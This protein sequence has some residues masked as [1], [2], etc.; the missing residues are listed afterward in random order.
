MGWGS[1]ADIFVDQE[2]VLDSSIWKASE[3]CPLDVVKVTSFH[4]TCV[5]L[6]DRMTNLK[7]E[8]FIDFFLM[9]LGT[10]RLD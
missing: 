3:N 5:I 10:Y 2:K 4:N 7:H 8:V 9:K 1:R 6:N